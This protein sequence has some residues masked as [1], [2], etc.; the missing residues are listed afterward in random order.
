MLAV[1]GRAAELLKE[2]DPECGPVAI[3]IWLLWSENG[4]TVCT[5][6]VEFAT[7]N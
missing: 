3:D 2:R 4:L 1:F 7:N 5:Y 6:E